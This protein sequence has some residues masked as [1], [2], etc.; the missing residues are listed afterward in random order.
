MNPYYI[1]RKRSPLFDI[2]NLGLNLYG[3][4]QRGQLSRQEMTQRAGIAETQQTLEAQKIAETAR[5]NRLR[6]GEPGGIMG[7]GTP[8]LEQQGIDIDTR[9]ADLKER[10]LDIREGEQPWHKQAFGLGDVSKFKQG[11][12]LVTGVKI[13]N[14]ETTFPTLFKEINDVAELKQSKAAAA[15]FIKKNWRYFQEKGIEDGYKALEGDKL[16]PVAKEKLTA[17]LGILEKDERGEI[18]E[19]VMGRTIQS[20]QMEMDESEPKLYETEEGWQ[21]AE[22]AVGLMKPTQ[23]TETPAQKSQRAKD[24]AFY[25]TTLVKPITEKT[26]RG[27][28]E[29]VTAAEANIL[30]EEINLEQKKPWV[31]YFNRYSNINY[32]YIITK[33]KEVKWGKDI[34]PNIKRIDLPKKDG[35]QITAAEVYFTAQKHGISYEEVLRR[36]KV[37]K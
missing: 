10:Q 19:Q 22:K 4:R 7:V 3:I 35:K 37:I 33:G 11:F 32:C 9:L 31:N 8:G 28:E 18:I 1:P 21:P 26:E 17:F 2:A 14:I 12:S 16:G 13:K 6:Y 29:K 27:F 15:L 20:M 25:K 23:P 30:D 24:L 5:V 34:A 36:L